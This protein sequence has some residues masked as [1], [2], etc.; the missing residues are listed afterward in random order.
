MSAMSDTPLSAGDLLGSAGVP[1][2]ITHNGHPHPLAPPDSL[3]VLDRVEKVIATQAAAEVAR[4]AE[5]MPRAFAAKQEADLLRRLRLREHA[6]GGAVWAEEFQADGGARGVLLVLYACLLEG[7]D[8]CRDKVSLP[9]PIGWDDLPAVLKSSPD[10][11]TVAALLVPDF[12]RAVGVR[13][14]LP[15]EAM[16]AMGEQFQKVAEAIRAG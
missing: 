14:N 10:A 12:F 13:K 7:R 16:E 5:Y 9:P 2:H 4:Q 11:Q 8:L 6:T 1:L 3:R 15:P